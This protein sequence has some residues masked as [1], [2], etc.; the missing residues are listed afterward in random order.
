ML[1][2]QGSCLCGDVRYKVI[3]QPKHITI[4]HCTF[5]QKATRSANMVEPIFDSHK[6]ISQ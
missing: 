6:K 3:A 2:E 4:C 1:A 5:C